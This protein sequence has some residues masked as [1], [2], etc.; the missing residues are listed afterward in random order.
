[1]VSRNAFI[2]DKSHFSLSLSIYPKLFQLPMNYHDLYT[3]VAPFLDQL[4]QDVRGK[5]G[6]G[7]EM[8]DPPEV[9]I[10]LITGTVLPAG[11]K[12]DRKRLMDMCVLCVCLF[13]LI[14]FIFLI[15]DTS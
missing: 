4:Q 9:A 10:C 6:G 7:A 14:G 13:F 5:K 12:L 15:F 11:A 3:M 8:R 2:Y 1:M